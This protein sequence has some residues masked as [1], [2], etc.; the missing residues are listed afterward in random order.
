MKAESK[1]NLLLG[2]NVGYALLLI[3]FI[4]M[5][6]GIGFTWIVQGMK[7]R[8]QEAAAVNKS[9]AEIAADAAETARMESASKEDQ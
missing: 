5:C 6:I 2:L 9:A 4:I 7:E 3:A 1:E 8:A